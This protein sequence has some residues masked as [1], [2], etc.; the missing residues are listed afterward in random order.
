[1]GR[2]RSRSPRWKRR[3][4][5]PAYR[6]SP[7]HYRPRPPYDHHDDDFRGFR[8][9]ARRPEPWR[10]KAGKIQ[11][12]NISRTFP[13]GNMH[14]KNFEHRLPLPEVKRMPLENFHRP[15]PQRKHHSPERGEGSRRKPN[16]PRR[17][18]GGSYREHEWHPNKI[19]KPLPHNK[20]QECSTQE[21]PKADRGMKLG[22]SFHRP[23]PVFTKYQEKHHIE[24]DLGQRRLP[25][26]K[27]S[28]SPKRSSEE[29]LGRSS[30]QE[31][32]PEGPDFRK[33]GH[34]AERAREMEKHDGRE[35]ARDSKWKLHH[36]LP[37]CYKE[38]EHREHARQSVERRY[39]EGSS[40]AKIAFEYDHKHPR[41]I[42][43]EGRLHF[44]DGK[45]ESCSSK[46]E[47]PVSHLAASHNKATSCFTSGM[48]RP[49]REGQWE[50]S[51]KYNASVK[52]IASP[53]ICKN[54][55]DLRL[56]HMEQKGRVG[57]E[58]DFRSNVDSFQ[59]HHEQNHRR[60]SLKT[61]NV[62]PKPETLTIKVDLKKAMDNYRPTSSHGAERQ[63]SQYLVAVSRKQ[64]DF[65]PVFEHMGSNAH[66]VE[67]TPKVEFTQEIIT[68]VHQVKDTYFKSPD[69]TLH[70]RFSNLQEVQPTN[71]KGARANSGPEI[72]RRIDMSLADLQSK[73]L[74]NWGSVQTTMKLIEDPND[75]RH[76]IER[77]RKRRLQDQEIRE[78][79]EE[80]IPQSRFSNE[81]TEQGSVS[82]VEMQEPRFVKGFQKPNRFI[83]KP[84]RFIRK[85]F[86]N[87]F[88]SGTFIQRAAFIQQRPAGEVENPGSCKRPF[89]GQTG[90]TTEN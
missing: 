28:Q 64:D 6:R 61:S 80:D 35:S 65:H 52:Y 49:A 32:Y 58:K 43:P 41:R 48:M 55:V 78:F 27:H 25:K 39:F 20:K 59:N 38:E 72:H 85:P 66:P 36:P 22:K 56:L 57:K 17:V 51:P 1:M 54:D 74:Q 50:T 34:S 69:L 79:N 70:E 75:L 86:M 14:P 13:H 83:Q 23:P 84:G 62:S 67:H 77:R 29:F 37:S 40:A 4:K 71:S 63:L 24:D 10:G 3:S 5:S 42:S 90:M 44:T 2:S 9:D 19:S 26:E 89:Q 11:G 7:E 82:A 53:N 33:F 8:K 46:V 16:F 45:A 60:M 87:K 88:H 68:L 30:Y 21:E 76:D 47:A 81:R 15:T 73:R 12:R 18:E 31:R